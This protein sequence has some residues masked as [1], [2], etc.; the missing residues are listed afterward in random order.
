MA[1]IDVEDLALK[2]DHDVV[3]VAVADANH[4]CRNFKNYSEFK[5]KSVITCKIDLHNF[6]L[7]VNTCG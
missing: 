3:I 7:K 4:K 1:V 2:S 5:L 6:P